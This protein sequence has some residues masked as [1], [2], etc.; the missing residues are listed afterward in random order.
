M[1]KTD[2]ELIFNKYDGK[3]AYCGCELTKG[4][5]ADHIEPIVRDFI[6]NKIKQRFEANGICRNPENENLQN[7][8][9]SCPSCNIQKNSYTLE[10]FRENIK[11]FVNSLNQ[12]STQ[13]KFAKKYGLVSETDIEVKFHF[14]TVS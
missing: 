5:H 10:Q 1:K 7:Y 6:Y 13:Y 4:W 14:E 9:P 2:R 12:Y 11:Q 3:C 8:N